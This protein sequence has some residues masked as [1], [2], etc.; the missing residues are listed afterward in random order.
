[1][2]MKK[3]KTPL[4]IRS[5]S[6]TNKKRPKSHRIV[7]RNLRTPPST[8]QWSPE[9]VEREYKQ[10]NRETTTTTD[11][12]QIIVN[13]GCKKDHHE[14][15]SCCGGDYSYYSRCACPVFDQ[16]GY[17]FDPYYGN[18]CGYRGYG[19]IPYVPSIAPYGLYGPYPSYPS[20][21]SYS[22]TPCGAVP[23]TY[24]H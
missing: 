14:K 5:L 17:A 6:K 2:P 15:E 18:G 11:G 24:P 12:T 13:C 23:V 8:P 3:K 10:A 21:P 4:L 20:Y 16:Y 1:M 19:G 7:T 9:P 22:Q